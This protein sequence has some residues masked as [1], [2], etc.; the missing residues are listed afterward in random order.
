MDLS[1]EYR[2]PASQ[3]QVWKALNDPEVLRQSIPG[4]QSLDK[5]E[6]TV[7][8][9]VAL[10]KVGPV[11]AKFTGSIELSDLNPP[12]SYTIAGQGKGGAAGFV[13]GEARVT[14]ISDGNETV[15]AYTVKANVGG[16]LAQVGQRLIDGAARKMA[17]DFFTNFAL[18]FSPAAMDIGTE[19]DRRPGDEA[20][21]GP[22]RRG[23]GNAN[24]AV[25]ASVLVVLIF[26]LFIVFGS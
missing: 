19:T 14:L 26:L 12:H 23:Y 16:K 22:I 24:W 13:K 5:V 6:E 21:T 9:A 20:P 4:C 11:K 10:A 3:E 8:H 25:V 17:D 1:G 18:T 15:L 2:I 7:Y